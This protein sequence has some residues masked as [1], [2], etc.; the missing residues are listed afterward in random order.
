MDWQQ[1]YKEDINLTHS[2]Q[3]CICS[4]EEGKTVLVL[5]H[6]TEKILG[7]CDRM[8]VLDKGEIRFD[9]TPLEGLKQDLEQWS[10]RNPLPSG[11]ECSEENLRS[12]LWL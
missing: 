12:L 9:G 3:H 8:I 5:T 4:V 10:I 6:E 1:K 7:L 11:A 2:H